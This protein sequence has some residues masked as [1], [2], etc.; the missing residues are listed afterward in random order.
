[1]YAA[2]QL[3]YY[4]LDGPRHVLDAPDPSTTDTTLVVLR[5]N[6]IDS[7]RN[8]LNVDVFAYPDDELV[9]EDAGVLVDGLFVRLE[10][11]T[12]IQE[13]RFDSDRVPAKVATTLRAQ[14]D[15]DNWPFDRYSTEPTT[16]TV[17]SDAGPAMTALDAQVEVA[18]HI[19]GWYIERA[20]SGDVVEITLERTRGSLAFDLGVCLILLSLP[21]MA[22]FV[23]I[24]T[25]WGGR[26]YESGHSALLSI[27]LFAVV[28]LRSILPGAPPP[29]AW[30][31]QTVVLWVLV[32]LVA[33]LAIYLAAWWRQSG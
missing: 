27:M 3:G 14:G 9:H 8:T 23:A 6:E 12:E 15:P 20:G 32:A 11:E 5:V 31:D 13:I 4:F 10:S 21:A 2:V 25:Y 22:L 28:P 16:V 17:L 33:A 19:D 29:G 24:G 1:M 7:F 18:G 30:V 26:K